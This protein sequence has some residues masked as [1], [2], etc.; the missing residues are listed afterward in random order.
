MCQW[1]II[2][3]TKC[4]IPLVIKEMQVKITIVYSYIPDKMAKV[5]KIDNIRYWEECEATRTC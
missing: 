2:R 1:P 3:Y 4:L 5:R